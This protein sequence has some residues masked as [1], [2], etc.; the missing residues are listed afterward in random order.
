[1]NLQIA[2]SN[3]KDNEGKSIQEEEGYGIR[4]TDTYC[5]TMVICHEMLGSEG[6]CLI[7]TCI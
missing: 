1:V 5:V 4:N 7:V 3:N 2:Q 6:K